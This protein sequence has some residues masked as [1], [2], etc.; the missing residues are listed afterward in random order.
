MEG[1]KMDINVICN[2]APTLNHSMILCIA[3][4]KFF[5]FLY[6]LKRVYKDKHHNVTFK[7]WNQ[8]SGYISNYNVPP[9][10]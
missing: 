1:Q 10:Y 2:I 3:I 4:V 7:H 9:N 5:P 8:Y 6:N